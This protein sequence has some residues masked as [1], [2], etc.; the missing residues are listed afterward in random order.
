MRAVRHAQA[1]RAAL[2]EAVEQAVA[3]AGGERRAERWRRRPGVADR[4][5]APRAASGRA[6]GRRFR[7]G[8]RRRRRLGRRAGS[9]FEAGRGAVRQVGMMGEVD[10]EADDHRVAAARAGCRR[11]WR[12]RRQ[13]VRP[14]D[15]R[16]SA[17]SGDDRLVQR[18]GGEQGQGRRR[19]ILGLQADE[20]RGVEIAGRRGPGPALPPASAL[21]RSA[22]SQRPSAAP[23]ARARRR[24]RWWSP[25][26]RR[27]GSEERPRRVAGCGASSR[28]MAR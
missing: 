19:R 27:C 11:A 9:A 26:R 5:R 22:R 14:F 24:R 20:R 1:Q 28:G 13:I 8:L 15:P 18:H 3:L 10:A 12:R 2:V 16:R 21:C 23:R 17:R 7:R 4:A 25:S 6:S